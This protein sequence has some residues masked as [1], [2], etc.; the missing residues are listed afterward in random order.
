VV[1]LVIVALGAAGAASYL[2]RR[3]RQPGP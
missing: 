2:V 1:P 3:R